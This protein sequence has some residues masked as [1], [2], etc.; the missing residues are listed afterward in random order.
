MAAMC[1]ALGALAVVTL[2]LVAAAL[3]ERPLVM[4]VGMSPLSLLGA[5]TAWHLIDD[6][7]GDKT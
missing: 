4:L 6:L 1:K 7:M 3:D 2:Y 5:E